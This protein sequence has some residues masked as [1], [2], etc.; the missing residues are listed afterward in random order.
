MLLTPVMTWLE[1]Q[2]RESRGFRF[3]VYACCA[4]CV[5]AG[6]SALSS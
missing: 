5:V 3:F 4:F 2:Y 1:T 6:L